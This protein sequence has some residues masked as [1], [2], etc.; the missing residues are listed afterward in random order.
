MTQQEIEATIARLSA[1]HKEYIEFKCSF[2]KPTPAKVAERM[3][4]KVKT[5]EKHCQ[6]VYVKLGVQCHEDMY[7][8]AVELGLVPCYCHHL[9][10]ARACKW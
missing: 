6:K 3:R 2:P 8:K 5:V 7:F 1:R 10:T 4:L 9:R